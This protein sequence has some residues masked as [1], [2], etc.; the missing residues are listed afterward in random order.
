[1]KQLIVICEGPTEHQFCQRVLFPLLSPIGINVQA[2]KIKRSGG[3]IVPWGT[4]S[5]EIRN[6]LGGAKSQ[7]YV[8]TM[9]DYYKIK[10]DFPN[11]TQSKSAIGE[12]GI[13]LM[14]KG[15]ADEINNHRF[16]PNLMRHEFEAILF[17]SVEPFELLFDAKRIRLNEI[18]KIVNLYPN[19]E[20]INDGEQTS[21]SKRIE[22][23]VPE[24]RK[25]IDGIEMAAYLGIDI[26]R[27]KC[28]HFNKWIERIEY[29][30]TNKQ[31]TTY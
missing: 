22:A 5:K 14:E 11:F 26:I 6:H 12:I 2:A 29:I 9:L 30:V 15:M 17:C 4:L 16:I 20:E 28:P 13:L 27:R 18:R 24:Y 19:P 21:P 25:P 8:T 7:V 3:G 23:N 10:N 31:N 1:M